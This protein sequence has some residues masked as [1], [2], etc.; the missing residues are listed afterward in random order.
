MGNL[1]ATRMKRCRLSESAYLQAT[2]QRMFYNGIEL[3]HT[4][5]FEYTLKRIL[6][7]AGVERV[8]T[9]GGRGF[10]QVVPWFYAYDM[11]RECPELGIGFIEEEY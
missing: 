8:F 6:Q 5:V 7:E 9:G 4:V 11:P 10:D 3:P 2:P 1:P